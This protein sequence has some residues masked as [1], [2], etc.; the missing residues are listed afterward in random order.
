M[1]KWLCVFCTLCIL[2]SLMPL[3]VLAIEEEIPEEQIE[4]NVGEISEPQSEEITEGSSVYNLEPEAEP[5][6]APDGD[7]AESTSPESSEPSEG[8]IEPSEGLNSLDGATVNVS[9]ESIEAIANAV[10]TVA[11][12]EYKY[13]YQYF[14][15]YEDNYILTI[16]TNEPDLFKDYNVVITKG[17]STYYLI[18]N[19][20]QAVFT[21]SSYNFGKCKF[22]GYYK[23]NKTVAFDTVSSLSTTTPGASDIFW[24]NYHIFDTSTGDLLFE[25]TYAPPIEYSVDFVT[26]FDDLTLDS[27]SVI[28]GNTFIVPDLSYEGYRFD[29]WYFDSDFT[30]PYNSDFSIDANVTLYAKWTPYLTISFDTGIEDFELDSIQVL[31]GEAY[32]PIQFSYPGYEFLG[33]YTDENYENQFVGGTIINADTT[34]YLRFEPIVYD[35]GS[36]IKETNTILTAM[37]FLMCICVST[38]IFNTIVGRRGK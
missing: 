6:E 4:E 22:T 3:S 1:R 27:L 37:L 13:Q 11:E 9:E 14:I 36:L 18:F 2:C 12:T 21:G 23:G 25:S 7:E 34:L 26:G 31:S 35:L 8:E 16:D 15:N 10:A 17:G 28:T 32:T 20:P 5:V 30:L 33:V 38:Y 29:G 24:S 19:P